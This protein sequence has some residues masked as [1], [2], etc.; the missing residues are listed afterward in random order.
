MLL[1][2]SYGGVSVKR[3]YLSAT[4]PE[5]KPHMALTEKQFLA[6]AV[7]KVYVVFTVGIAVLRWEDGWT[8]VIAPSI[9]PI[10]RLDYVKSRL[11][12]YETD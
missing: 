11:K 8:T 1:C 10:G 12:S 5:A 2:R 7:I 6:V 9:W 4:C 3:K